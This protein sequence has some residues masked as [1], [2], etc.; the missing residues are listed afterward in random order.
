MNG[1]FALIIATLFFPIKTWI[2]WKFLWNLDLK[3]CIFFNFCYIK[4]EKSVKFVIKTCYRSFLAKLQVHKWP[5]LETHFGVL[6]GF[7][8]PWRVHTV[9]I[10]TT[11]STNKKFWSHFCPQWNGAF[12]AYFISSSHFFFMVDS[13]PLCISQTS[14]CKTFRMS[15]FGQ[16][17]DVIL[18]KICSKMPKLL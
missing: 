5:I 1:Y 17:P 16:L 13:T 11:W 12:G 2:F 14:F 6:K 18:P 4:L 15:Y 3:N 7:R 10:N 8:G 9:P